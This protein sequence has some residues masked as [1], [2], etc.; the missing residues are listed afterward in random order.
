MRLLDL[1]FEELLLE[2]TG[3]EIY[4]KYYKDIPL[5]TFKQI[6]LSDPK[7]VING[8]DIRNIGTY[9]KMLLTMFKRKKLHM[10][11]L[12]SFHDYLGYIYKYNIPIDINKINEIGDLYEY[13]KKYKLDEDLTFNNAL[14][15]LN[16]DEYTVLHDGNEWRIYQPLDEKSACYLGVNAE[17]CTTWG[18]MSLTKEFK[19][20]SNR[21]DGYKNSGG[22]HLYILVKKSNPDKERFQ[23]QFPAKQFMDLGN[24]Q[25]NIKQFF[26]DNDEMAYFFFPSLIGKETDESK[27]ETTRSQYLGDEERRK[28]FE[29]KYKNGGENPLIKGIMDNDDELVNEVINDD[30]LTDNVDVNKTYVTF[31]VSKIEN[32]IQE[33]YD[34]I[35]NAD[36]Y[37]NNS[38]NN[39]AL[40]DEMKEYI[41]NADE[42][43]LLDLFKEYYAVNKDMI[44]TTFGYNDEKSFYDD[45]FDDFK[46]DDNINSTF[47]NES[48]ELSQSNFD[49]SIE[50]QISDI[51]KYIDINRNGKEYDII[52]DLPELVTYLTTHNITGINGDLLEMLDSYCEQIDIPEYI[53]TYNFEHIY[54]KY[55]NNTYLKLSV[56]EF[57]EEHEVNAE[58]V[59]YKKML[60]NI[61]TK[62]FDE[63]DRAQNDHVLIKVRNEKVD[64]ENGT[65]EIDLWNKQTNQMHNGHVKI[66]ALPTY[67]QNYKLFESY[68]RYK[69]IL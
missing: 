53:E 41:D 69:N 18:P 3:N 16:P 13:I 55:S 39:D 68:L 30:I 1:I 50:D 6:I 4:E 57:F 11:D 31:S 59:E 46:D 62:F 64:C 56:D 61:L 17:W 8:D 66:S 36:Y 25:I 19:D 60:N 9:S 12:P 27:W 7:T 49:A 44:A 51:K 24:R 15:Q 37:I 54:P 40:Y 43:V 10:E 23:F 33:V 22:Q 28:L 2:I 58:C 29:L 26:I 67:L 32:T 42:S 47:L 65:V 38:S 5:D 35:L 21:F 45:Y 20:R 52:C 34:V 63:D 48:V 14:S